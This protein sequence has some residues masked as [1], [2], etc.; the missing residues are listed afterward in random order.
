MPIRPSERARYPA[1]WPAISLRIRERAGGRCECFGDCGRDHDEEACAESV[2]YVEARCE[3]QNGRP[4]PVTGSKVVL[5]VAHLN[6]TPEDCRD[7]NLLAMCQ[8]CH[9]KYDA[10]HHAETRAARKA[11]EL[12]AQMNTLFDL[13][14][15]GTP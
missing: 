14:P 5:T 7:V 1:D 2:P 13:P 11:A 12:S 6:H 10:A 4:H 9:L 3:A 15:E 8:R